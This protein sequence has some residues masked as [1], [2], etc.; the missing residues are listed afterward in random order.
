MGIEGEG[1][2]FLPLYW[3]HHDRWRYYTVS[4][5]TQHVSNHYGHVHFWM[6]GL[7]WTNDS[8]DA[9]SGSQTYKFE[10][11]DIWGPRSD[12]A[13]QQHQYTVVG[14]PKWYFHVQELWRRVY[15][16][17][18]DLKV[19]TQKVAERRGIKYDAC[20][21]DKFSG[22]F[23]EGRD[24]RTSYA[25]AFLKD[26]RT[27]PIDYYTSQ[28]RLQSQRTNWVKTQADLVYGSPLDGS[29]PP[30]DPTGY[31]PDTYNLQHGNMLNAGGEQPHPAAK[32]TFS[33]RLYIWPLIEYQKV[34]QMNWTRFP[35]WEALH[36][37]DDNQFGDGWSVDVEIPF[38]DP[39]TGIYRS[40]FCSPGTRIVRPFGQYFNGLVDGDSVPRHPVVTYNT[41][42]NPPPDGE[43]GTYYDDPGK[44]PPSLSGQPI[45]WHNPF[46][47][48]ADGR[49]VQQCLGGMVMARAEV[50]IQHKFGGRHTVLVDQTQYLPSTKF[51]GT[52]QGT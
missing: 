36:D 31:Q 23:R 33:D 39:A 41:E 40:P 46:E 44:L 8:Q 30:Y 28:D 12:D 49:W 7:D 2:S 17:P 50:T 32:P 14:T 19:D 6:M 4:G 34:T 11:K 48:Q 25:P 27:L 43:A 51:A 9:F 15:V 26:A 29:Y 22:P 37:I 10:I 5:G 35:G 47:D 3:I 16:Q 52:D 21:D 45:T 1:I 42:D 13:N 38:K 24:G 20:A 18:W